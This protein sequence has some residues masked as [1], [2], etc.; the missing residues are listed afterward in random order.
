M[1]NKENFLKALE[2][3]R[4]NSKKRKFSQAV[5]LIIN[6]KNVDLKKNSIDNFIVLPHGFTKQIKVCVVVDDDFVNRAKGNCDKVI[7]KS[8]LEKWSNSKDV[9]SLGKEFGFFIAQTNLMGLIATKF[10]RILGPLGKMPNPKFGGVVAPGADLKPFVEKFRKGIRVITRNEPIFKT[11]IGYEDMKDADIVDNAFHVYD[12]II[13]SL[14]HGE[15]NISSA[16][17]KFTMSEPV[18][19]GAKA[20]IVETKEEKPK[21]KR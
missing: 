21:K 6:F 10:G 2:Q 18:V 1:V 16:I 15:I 14:P 20:S 4:K 8:E 17:I 5:D 11:K 3:L 19:V 9:K 12:S 7:G 13:H